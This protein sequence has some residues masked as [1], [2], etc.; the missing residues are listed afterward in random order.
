MD[1]LSTEEC[2]GG[3]G[4]AATDSADGGFI[5]DGGSGVDEGSDDVGKYKDT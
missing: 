1:V 4:A 2:A 3:G 5:E